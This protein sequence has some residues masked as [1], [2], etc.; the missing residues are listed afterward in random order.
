VNK[1]PLDTDTLS[2]IGKA[3]NPVI[4]VHADT[5][6]KVFGYY[7]FSTVTVLEIVRGYQKAQQFQRLHAFIAS[8]ASEEVFPLDVSD[9]EFAGRITGDLDRTGQPIGRADPMIAAIA[10]VHESGHDNRCLAG[11]DQRWGMSPSRGRALEV[12]VASSLGRL[13]RPWQFCLCDTPL[14]EV[15]Q[16]LR[17]C[18][19]IDSN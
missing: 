2:E 18:E 12:P 8:I 4:A 3:K 6:R 10:L 17:G 5:Y 15:A 9:A 13:H 1:A 11:R 14:G 7:S 19:R 16:G